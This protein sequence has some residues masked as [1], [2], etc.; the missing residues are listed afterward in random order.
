MK[1]KEQNP[2]GKLQK[3]EP[4]KRPGG[5]KKSRA[6][7]YNKTE[8]DSSGHGELTEKGYYTTMPCGIK[9]H[10]TGEGSGLKTFITGYLQQEKENA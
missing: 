8:A 4:K 1:K 7:P 5:K 6:I 2:W 9:T 10:V 3:K